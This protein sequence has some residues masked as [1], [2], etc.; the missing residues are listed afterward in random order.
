MHPILFRIPL[1]FSDDG[2]PVYS[3][4]F[5]LMVAFVAGLWVTARRAQREG[6]PPQMVLDLGLYVI[7]SGI[8]GARLAFIVF[9][10]ETP[11]TLMEYF[12]IWHGGLTFQ[13]GLFLALLVC[14]W[15]LKANQLPAG[16]IADIF[17]PGL[18]LGVALGRIGCFLNGCCWGALCRP[19]FP[20]GV[21]FP[22]E[23]N[24]WKYHMD[25]W[26][27]GKLTG[28]MQQA[29]YA[30]PLP[31]LP[32]SLPLPVH[33]AQLYATVALLGVCALL[34]LFDRLPRLFD[35]M[36]MLCFLL[37]YSAARFCLELVRDDTPLYFHLGSF[38]GLRLGQILALLTFAV[39]AT[40]FAYF[41]CKSRGNR[42]ERR[43]P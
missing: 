14:I 32:E 13:G 35:G 17:A 5:M 22:P 19:D 43:L 27:S 3:Y 7:V 4:G 37:L 10:M 26:Q 2:L 31:P 12:A 1:P 39:A 33:P 38:P 15:F 18:A 29:G 28:M 30:P 23:S 9:D 16:K 25:L 24:V 6:V 40:L 21:R 36:L 42:E 41:Y 34:L 11:R 20:L 8:I